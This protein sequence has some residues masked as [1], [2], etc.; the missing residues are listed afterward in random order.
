MFAHC[1]SH[2]RR[3][4]PSAAFPLVLALTALARG[5]CVQQRY[6]TRREKPNFLGGPL[7]LLT[8]HD[9]RPT[10]RTLQLLRRYDLVTLQEKNPEIALTKLQQEI[11][12]D[13]NP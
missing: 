10:A 13:P 3:C 1:D 11:E 12:T 6:I 9:P 5:G 4:V 8:R 7:N 2:L